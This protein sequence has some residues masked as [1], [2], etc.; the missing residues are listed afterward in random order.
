MKK[1]LLYTVIGVAGYQYFKSKEN[2]EKATDALNK[3]YAGVESWISK[4]QQSNTSGR[5]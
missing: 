1:L 3:F 2:R 5:S 4:L